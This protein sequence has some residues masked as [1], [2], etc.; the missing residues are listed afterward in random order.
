MAATAQI[1]VQASPQKAQVSVSPEGSVIVNASPA[2]SPIQI[3]I[4]PGGGVSAGITQLTGDVTAGPGFG[5]QVTT[6]AATGV[7]AGSYTNTNLT[8]DAKGRVTSAANGSGGGA[9]PADGFTLDEG[10][11]VA[12]GTVT[13]SMFGTGPTEKL[14]FWGV[15]PTTQPNQLG[16]VGPTVSSGFDSIDK[17]ELDSALLT[18][19]DA[20]NALNAR[21]RTVGIVQP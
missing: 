18:I 9:D 7:V 21:L 15:T 20:I 14:A 4:A 10:A 17:S 3:S 16:D 8:V 5:S 2:S 6:L 12:A 13:G 11:N 1:R 19:S